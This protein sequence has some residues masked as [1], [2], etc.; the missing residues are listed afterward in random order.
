MAECF[1]C[2]F[3]PGTF[4][5]RITIQN[6]SQT[7]DDTGASTTVWTDFATVWCKIVPKHGNEQLIAQR[8]DAVNIYDITIRFFPGVV[9]KMRVVYGSKT[10]QIKSVINIDELS[11]FMSLLCIDTGPGT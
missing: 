6:L 3:A 10:F 9:E 4:K 11:E 2:K 1:G 8:V 7:L 5:Q